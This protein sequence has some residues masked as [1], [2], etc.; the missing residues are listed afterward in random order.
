MP[1]SLLDERIKLIS[2][3]KY[4]YLSNEIC[5]FVT[6]GI[7]FLTISLS[8][9]DNLLKPGNISPDCNQPIFDCD[10][11]K[12]GTWYHIALQPNEKFSTVK[13]VQ[14]AT[15]IIRTFEMTNFCLQAV[16]KSSRSLLTHSIEKSDGFGASEDFCG[17]DNFFRFGGFSTTLF[18]TMPK[19]IKL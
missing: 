18:S 12:Q 6:Y 14:Y 9:S 13:S 17:S 5:F 8:F 19:E 7:C 4:V 10:R 1:C 15:F 3:S 16:Q 2:Q 11:T